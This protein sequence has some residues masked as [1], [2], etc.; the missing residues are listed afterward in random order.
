G[1]SSRGGLSPAAAPRTLLLEGSGRRRRRLCVTSHRT[2][3]AANARRVS[4]ATAFSHASPTA[5]PV[6]FAQR[7]PKVVSGGVPS[8]QGPGP[9]DSTASLSRSARSR[10]GPAYASAAQLFTTELTGGT[11]PSTSDTSRASRHQVDG[12]TLL[13]LS[14][15]SVTIR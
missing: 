6:R 15:A 5:H 2:C 3:S 8:P 1:C 4:N 7:P 12:C 13:A 14:Y 9:A 10:P 11:Q